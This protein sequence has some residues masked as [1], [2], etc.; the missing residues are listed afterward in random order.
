MCREGEWESGKG[1]EKR[2]MCR[3]EEWERR[4]E[5]DVKGRGMGEWAVGKGG[6]RKRMWRSQG[7]EVLDVEE[8]R[9]G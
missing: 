5:K 7:N 9:K 1:G 3:V 2:R 4:E 8:L 6:E